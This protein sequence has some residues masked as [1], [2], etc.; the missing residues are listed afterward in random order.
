MKVYNPY[1]KEIIGEIHLSDTSALQ[2]NVELAQQAKKDMQNLSSA[3]KKAILQTIIDELYTQ[4]D[5]LVRIIIQESGKPYKYA[6]GEVN[7]AIQ[8]FTLAKE[9]CNRLPHE[10]FDLDATEKGTNLRGEMIYFPRGIILGIAPFNFPLNLVAHKVAPAIAAGCP[11]LLKPSER[12]PLTATFLQN[13]IRK[14]SLPKG[15]FQVIHC[16]KEQTMQLVE[17][18]AISVVSFTGSA[19]VGWTIKAAAKKK[20]VV[21]ELGGNAAAILTE[22][23]D[24]SHAVEELVIGGFAYSGQVCIHTQRVYVH[25]HIYQK[26]MHQFLEK[27]AQLE[28][29]DPLLPTTDFGILIDEK[30]AKRVAN[31]VAEAISDGAKCLIGGERIN[32]FYAPTVLT[33]VGKKQK[34]RNLEVFGPVVIVESY[35][36]L[37]DAIYE[38]NDC[39]WGLQASIFTNKIDVLN[40][41]FNQLDTG[42]IIHNKSTAFRVDEMPYGGVKSSGFGREGV[43]FAIRDFL[44]PKLLVRASK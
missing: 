30:N 8:T 6:K 36:Q 43:R 34:V 21:L 9:E 4:F 41:A 44:E 10:I 37:E 23:T 20:Y 25:E 35:K 17:N 24:I 31:W 42:A 14:T 28:I 40:Q 27:I 12:T 1:N 39:E 22:D 18:D 5:A 15:G 19:K 16:A 33:N 11:I 32:S 26:F 29:G 38:I 7:R 2:Q 3:E 13:I